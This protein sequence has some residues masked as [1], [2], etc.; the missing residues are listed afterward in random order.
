MFKP[1]TLGWHY[2][3]NLEW[4]YSLKNLDFLLA[5]LVF[6]AFI[7]STRSE[8]LFSE[9][10]TEFLREV[11]DLHVNSRAENDLDHLV[12]TI[13]QEKLHLYASYCNC[14]D[15]EKFSSFCKKVLTKFLTTDT[16]AFT[17]SK[18]ELSKHSIIGKQKIWFEM[19]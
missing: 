19:K 9:G 11:E 4:K 2:D 12:T 15:L 17:S 6:S 8:C 14:Q 10:E 13:S 5:V 3:F 1:Y 7:T 16:E 18:L